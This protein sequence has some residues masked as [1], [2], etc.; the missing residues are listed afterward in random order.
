MRIFTIVNNN[1]LNKV[2]I[3]DVEFELSEQKTVLQTVLENGYTVNH[4]CRDGRCQECQIDITNN[5]N[6]SQKLACQYYPTNGDSIYFDVFENYK[7]P[8]Q[9]ISPAKINSV[10][11]I[12]EYYTLIE[13]RIPPNKDFNFFAGQYI[14]INIPTV[15]VRP[16]SIYSLNI[17]NKTLTILVSK[18]MGGLASDFFFKKAKKEFLVTIKGPF[19]SFFYR[20]KEAQRVIFCATGSGIA[21]I[22]AIFENAQIQAD[23]S[24]GTEVHL[25][26][27]N[28]YS[29]DFFEL[30]SNIPKS[31]KY[32]RFVT[33]ENGKSCRS[34]RIVKPT[35]ELIKGFPH[36]EKICVYACGN[37]DFISELKKELTKLGK[38]NINFY[39]DAF[40]R[41]RKQQ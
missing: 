17:N 6:T 27:S 38:L 36:G 31:V 22:N 30:S 9:I 16:Y 13:F 21:P 28:K 11:R 41:D 40:I 12:N 25:L 29:S 35:L 34:G 19:G 26:W 32:N 37:P 14:D 4:S 33:R 20:P 5:G 10:N 23:L 24:L 8:D 3:N 39:S 7:L 15:G 2:M 1:T 18:V